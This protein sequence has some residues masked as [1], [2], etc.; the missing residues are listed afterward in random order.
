MISTES[1]SSL[2]RSPERIPAGKGITP[3][4]VSQVADRVYAMLLAELKLE[5]ERRRSK[6]GK[7]LKTRGGR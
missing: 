2:N 4:L 7:P 1:P 6:G 3:E 5:G